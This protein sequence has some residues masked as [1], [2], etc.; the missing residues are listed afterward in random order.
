M[1]DLST[2]IIPLK[3]IESYSTT[4]DYELGEPFFSQVL[5][6]ED[7]IKGGKLRASVTVKKLSH[8][9]E[10]SFELVGKVSVLCDRCLDEMDIKITT[11]PV[12]VVKYGEEHV[13]VD[14]ELVVIPEKEGT[15]N[16]AWYFYEY[17]V[18]ALPMQHI[19]PKGKCNKEMEANLEKYSTKE[20]AKEENMIDPRWEA[21]KNIQN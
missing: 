20:I 1:S 8:S 11:S 7:D 5:S 13:D 3:S 15:I 18:L 14:E 10:L 17:M 4:Y 21:L 9:F 16:I 6:E 12:L 2:Y 19:H